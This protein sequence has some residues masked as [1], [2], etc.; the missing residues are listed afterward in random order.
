M[1]TLN[2][3]FSGFKTCSLLSLKSLPSWQTRRLENN[4]RV[5]KLPESKV[6]K[7]NNVCLPENFRKIE[8]L[9][10]QNHQRKQAYLEAPEFSRSAQ[11]TLYIAFESCFTPP[12]KSLPSPTCF[13]PDTQLQLTNCTPLQKKNPKEITMGSGGDWILYL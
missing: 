10:F 6:G 2:S 4:P 13:P 9:P 8:S 12:R 3:T 1:R 7:L 5:P 11:A